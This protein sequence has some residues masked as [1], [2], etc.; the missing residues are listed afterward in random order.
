MKIDLIDVFDLILLLL[1]G[2]LL[3]YVLG[4][5]RQSW[6]LTFAATNTYLILPVVG[7]V[8]IRVI[9]ES[10]SLSL[11]LIGALSIVRFRH[12]VRS[13]LELTIYFVLLST[14]IAMSQRQDLAIMLVSITA[15]TILFS[16]V[17]ARKTRLFAST[18]NDPGGQGQQGALLRVISSASKPDLLLNQ[19]LVQ[20]VKNPDGSHEYVLSYELLS[21]AKDLFIELTSA[22]SIVRLE[23]DS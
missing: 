18:P 1:S 7:Y 4:R 10:I 16:G 13:P 20:A 17:A 22:D 6:A 3:R 9:S 14:G 19:N 5:A 2:A 12:P 15:L 11:G 8:I 21:D 23:F